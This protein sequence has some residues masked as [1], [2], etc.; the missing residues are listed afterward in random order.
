MKEHL[1]ALALY[2]V[3]IVSGKIK[4]TPSAVSHCI[5]K[6]NPM[7]A[8]PNL[9]PENHVYDIHILGIPV[10]ISPGF[11]FN[12]FALWGG[13]TWLQWRRHPAWRWPVQVFTAALSAL[14]LVLADVGHAFAHAVGA[15]VAAAPMDKVQLT[16]GMPRTIYYDDSVPPRAHILRAIGG[17]I[18]SL[19]GLVISLAARSISPCNTI[20]REVASWSSIGHGFIFAGSLAPLPIVDGGSILKW[21]LVAS[22]KT[23]PQADHIVKQA[24]FATGVASCT[25]GAALVTR[26]RWLPAACLLAAGLIAIAAARGK[27]R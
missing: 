12:L 2:F 1:F 19:L 11:V 15:R 16:S 14:A 5:R 6:G 25:V 3:E 4:G 24:G 7:Q 8:Y 27:I 18:F 26:R 23:P 20:A 17:P 22:G 10:D 13:M 9:S 21:S